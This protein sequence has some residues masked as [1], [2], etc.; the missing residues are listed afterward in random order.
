[1]GKNERGR[2]SGIV[3]VLKEAGGFGILAAALVG[4]VAE[5]LGYIFVARGGG[6]MLDAFVALN[7]P[8]A[9]KHMLVILLFALVL[10]A[11]IILK[12]SLL[13]QYQEQGMVRLRARTV[14]ALG[15]AQMAWL[16]AR[17]TGELSARVSNDL[18]ALGGALRPVLILGIS[19][20]LARI[21]TICFLFYIDWLLTLIIFAALPVTTALQWLYSRPIKKYRVANQDAVGALSSVVYDCFGG[22]ETVKSLSLE[23]EMT[24]RFEHAQARQLE[25]AVRENK[26]VAALTPLSGLGRYLPQFLL[27][28]VGGIFIISGRITIGQMAMFLMLSSSALH[29]LGNITELIAAIR[30]LFVAADRIVQLWDVPREREG[31]AAQL[32]DGDAALLEFGAVSFSYAGDAVPAAETGAH[33]AGTLRNVCFS[34]LPGSFTALVGES[35]CGKSTVLKLAAAL[36]PPALGGVSLMGRPLTDWDMRAMRRHIAY[37]TQETFLFPGTLRENIMGGADT[38]PEAR[39]ARAIEAAQL[40]DFVASLPLG[41]D[42]VV[43]ERGVFLSGGQRQRISVARALCRDVS[44]LLL[45]E[46]TSALDQ[47]TESM[48]IDAL[49]AWPGRPALLMITHRLANTRNADH[50][51]VMKDGAVCQSGVYDALAREDGEYARLLSLQEGDVAF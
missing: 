13:G 45:D 42:T 28:L 29:A 46:A 49:L 23:D 1:V 18:N 43:G 5:G 12:D 11:G 40:K 6:D 24:A 19:L 9:V 30:Q 20:L 17:H 7:G 26:V 10:G 37:V 2:T 15:R 44:L 25:A 34:V 31:G 27:V 22:F 3:R 36:Y 51:I 48:L 38:I 39:F 32:P 33:H 16:D 47:T 8:N 41:L 21:M 50:I 35:G 4:N 14:S